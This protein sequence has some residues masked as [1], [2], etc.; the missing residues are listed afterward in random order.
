MGSKTWDF[1]WEQRPY[2]G[3]ETQDPESLVGTQGLKSK[4]SYNMICLRYALN[5]KRR[6]LDMCSASI[7]ID[8]TC[9]KRIHR[10]QLGSKNIQAKI[11]RII[12]YMCTYKSV[13][14]ITITITHPYVIIICKKFPWYVMTCKSCVVKKFHSIHM[15]L[16][17]SAPIQFLMMKKS[18]VYNN[19]YCLSLKVCFRSLFN[20]WV[21]CLLASLSSLLL[22]TIVANHN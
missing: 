2:L 4:A 6:P 9:W 10:L 16:F 14:T 11:I 12:M 19:N 15:Q 17:V 20:F 5:E 22:K 7:S 1:R 13:V 18:N 21:H 8:L 3:A